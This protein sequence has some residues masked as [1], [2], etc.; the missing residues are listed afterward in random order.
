MLTDY[1]NS[2]NGSNSDISYSK[3]PNF[4]LPLCHEQS[5]MHDALLCEISGHTYFQF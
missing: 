5:P 4:Y 3:T 1:H 2:S